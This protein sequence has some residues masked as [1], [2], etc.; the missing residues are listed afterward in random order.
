MSGKSTYIRSIALMTVMA[1]VGCFVPA[2]YAS[3]PITHQLFARVSMDDS[4]EANVSTF[5]SEMRETAFIL[6][7]IDRKSLAIIDELGRGTSSRDGLTIALSI[8]E[9]LVETKALVWFATHFTDL[10][11][12]RNKRKATGL[13]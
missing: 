6:R 7:N 1:Q 2:Q 3:F 13:C 9:A 5:A 10:G 4:I 11:K 12:P 8:S